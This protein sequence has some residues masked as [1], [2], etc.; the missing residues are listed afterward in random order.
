MCTYARLQWPH[1]CC[2]TSCARHQ[3]CCA[4]AT[5]QREVGKVSLRPFR[6]NM[7]GWLLHPPQ[8]SAYICAPHLRQRHRRHFANDWN[9]AASRSH[10]PHAYQ[11][12]ATP[13]QHGATVSANR[14]AWAP[15]G[16]GYQLAIQLHAWPRVVSAPLKNP[17][18]PLP[19]PTPCRSSTSRTRP[20]WARASAC[21]PAVSPAPATA[22]SSAWVV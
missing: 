18:T 6:R 20:R 7:S 5:V 1:S 9:S 10:D 8:I 17:G 15:R 3:P 19:P 14:P 4:R 16:A 2:R 21:A 11:F 13:A 22:W 12:S